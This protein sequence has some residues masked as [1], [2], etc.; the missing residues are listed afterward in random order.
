M[1]WRLTTVLLAAALAGCGGGGG[2]E[3]AP[4]PSP[5]AQEDARR[6][7]PAR[8]PAPPGRRDPG[9]VP[10]GV[11]STGDGSGRAPAATE[12]V[13]R[14]WTAAVRRADFPAAGRLFARR[15]L[16]QNGGPVL[17]LPNARSAARWNA[18]LPCGARVTRV[19][20]AARGY[21]VVRFRLVERRGG[22]C[23]SGTGATARITVK[24][25]DGRIREWYRLPD[26]GAGVPP[27]DAVET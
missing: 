15:A 16:V 26:P 18:L 22:D 10:P 20:R 21:A 24:V 27:A 3:P 9:G 2:D 17:I 11:P 13:V 6:C 25:A 1:R 14:A 7:S 4:G 12:R 8:P 5:R 19:D 23:G